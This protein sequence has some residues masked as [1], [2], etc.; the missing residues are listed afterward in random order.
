MRLLVLLALLSATSVRGPLWAQDRVSY[1][2]KDGVTYRVVTRTVRRPLLE[3]QLQTQERTVYRPKVTTELQTVNRSYPVQTIRFEWTPVWE[4][5]W[6][7]F[8]PPPLVY[9]QRPIVQW[10]NRQEN[11]KIPVSKT[12]LVAEKVVDTLPVTQLR[13]VE[14]TYTLERVAIGSRPPTAVAAIPAASPEPRT[15]A[16]QPSGK[17]ERTDQAKLPPRWRGGEKGTGEVKR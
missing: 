1:E 11:V 7:P 3:T 9:R 4:R 17:D 2:E 15:A 10:E 16:A 5:S 6:N 13:F 12:E 14:D 8:A